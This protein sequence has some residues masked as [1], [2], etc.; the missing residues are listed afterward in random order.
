MNGIDAGVLPQIAARDVVAF[1]LVLGRVGPL[2]LL[3]PV[4]S[5]RM[6]PARVKALLAG[7]IAMVL[8]PIAMHGQHIPVDSLD[9]APLMVKEITI[10]LAFALA[11]GVLAAGIQ[12][13]GSL[14][15]TLI[16]FSFGALV[17]PFDNSPAAILGQLYSIFA[18]MVF[19]LTGGDQIMV[20]GLSK[21]YELVP[22]GG[23][24]ST[25]HLAALATTGLA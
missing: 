5:S 19:L 17:D 11:I 4:F 18:T 1:I 12:A 16:G 23:M 10:G 21:S 15:D 2:F 3:A 6:I 8:T 14:L 13:A 25:G 9:V 7:G 22:L 24:P 20:L